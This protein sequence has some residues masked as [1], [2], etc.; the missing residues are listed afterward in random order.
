MAQ[1][2]VEA[3]SVRRTQDH[4]SELIERLQND[5]Q[6]MFLEQEQETFGLRH[7]SNEAMLQRLKH[8]CKGQRPKLEQFWDEGKQQYTS[9]PFEWAALIKNEV[10][11]RQGMQ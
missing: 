9:D 8:I 7:T 11:N 3:E 5:R 6:E 4:V 1:T 10:T 2:G